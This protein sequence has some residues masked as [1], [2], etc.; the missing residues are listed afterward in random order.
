MKATVDDDLG[1]WRATLFMSGRPPREDAD[2]LDAWTAASQSII[3][4]PVIGRLTLL[5]STS[6]ETR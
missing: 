2:A 6:S 1:A 4:A 3:T 5:L